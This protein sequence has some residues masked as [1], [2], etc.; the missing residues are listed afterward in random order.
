VAFFDMSNPDSQ[1]TDKPMVID[2]D[3]EPPEFVDENGTYTIKE[4]LPADENPFQNPPFAENG[5]PDKDVILIE[6]DG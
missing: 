2:P 5:D 4:I 1:T 3:A 6:T